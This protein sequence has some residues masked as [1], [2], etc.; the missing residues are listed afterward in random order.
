M[1][2]N[3]GVLLLWK[4][5]WMNEVRKNGFYSIKIFSGGGPEWQYDKNSQRIVHYAAKFK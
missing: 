3:L 4:S 1:K 2:K 5:V